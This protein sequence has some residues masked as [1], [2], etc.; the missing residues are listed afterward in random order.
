MN[1]KNR[2]FVL[3]SVVILLVNGLL[4]QQGISHFNDEIDNT[5]KEQEKIID[6]VAHEILRNSYEPY[7]FKIRFFVEENEQIRQAFAEQDRKL[8]YSLS[9]SIYRGLHGE[10]RFFHAMDFN[11]PDGTVFLRVQ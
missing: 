10:N 2:A 3:V 7:L 8:L 4:L 6:D 1:I 5:V 11:L 9:A